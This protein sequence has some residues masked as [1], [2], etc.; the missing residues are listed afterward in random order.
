MCTL[1]SHSALLTVVL[2]DLRQHGVLR[3]VIQD[4][5]SEVNR[6]LAGIEHQV[7]VGVTIFGLL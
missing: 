6:A 4:L 3:Y 7:L 5:F 1:A 2:S